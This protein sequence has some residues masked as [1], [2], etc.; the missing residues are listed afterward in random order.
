[1]WDIQKQ[2]NKEGNNHKIVGYV[3]DFTHT[4]ELREYYTENSYIKY[5]K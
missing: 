4:L 1:M 5:L 3:D 2:L